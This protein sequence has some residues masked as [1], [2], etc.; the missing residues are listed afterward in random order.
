VLSYAAMLRRAADIMGRKRLLVPVPLLTPGLSSWWLAL[1]TDVDTQAG[2]SLVD[3]MTNE[4][5]V[6]DSSIRD[7]VPFDPMRYDE[8]VTRALDEHHSEEES[9]R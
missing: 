1:V 5:V 9:A 7:V 2:R 4:V 3:S 8:A 6:S